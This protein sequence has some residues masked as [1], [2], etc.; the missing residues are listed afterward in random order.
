MTRWKAAAA[1][2]AIVAAIYGL[3]PVG[4]SGDS[5]WTTPVALNLLEHGSTDL[6]PYADLA[7]TAPRHGGLECI[8]QPGYTS[9]P[10]AWCEDGTI[11]ASYPVA[12]AVIAAGPVL[13]LR[14]STYVV[15]RLFHPHP[16]SPV[17]RA[18]LAGDF[19][20]SYPLVEML[21]ASGLMALAA[22]VHLLIALEFLPLARASFLT[23]LFAFATPVWSTASRAMWNHTPALL[24]LITA[25]WLLV[26]ARRAEH[27]ATYASIPLSLAFMMRPTTAISV[28]L[29][30]VYVGIYHRRRLPGYLAFAAALAIPF[31]AY[32][33]AVRHR[34]FQL[35]FTEQGG[36]PAA[37]LVERFGLQLVSPSRGLFIFSP[38]LLFSLYGIWLAFRKRWLYPL[39]PWLAAILG[40]QVLLVARYYWPG[41][42][43]GP[44]YFT[45]VI[46]LLTIF[47]IP[48]FESWPALPR[49]WQALFFLTLAWSVFVHA[50]GATDF[51]VHL[52]NGTPAPVDEV[53]AWDW[54]DPQFL[55]GL[56]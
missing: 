44:R 41:D 40:L 52:W 32:N 56:H 27:F 55:R 38:V 12:V 21:I 35:Y 15:Q 54:R 2:I 45:E 33:L 26:L 3:C 10:R 18:F 50:R 47:L 4:T 30:T 53:R 37:P 13:L 9:T 23:F 17:L 28:A 24:M 16:A 48:V 29:L 20:S 51:R 6:E 34:L 43:Y 46:P 31:F 25:V 7:L 49:P 8:A 39:A 36:W 19:I 42:C 14:I 22:G 5:R 1:H 11:Y